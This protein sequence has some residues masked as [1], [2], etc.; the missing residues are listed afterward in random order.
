MFMQPSKILIKINL[1]IDFKIILTL[2]ATRLGCIYNIETKFYD[3]LRITKIV[4]FH[5]FL[6]DSLHAI[7]YQVLGDPAPGRREASVSPRLGLAAHEAAGGGGGGVLGGIIVRKQCQ[8][9]IKMFNF[10]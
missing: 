7:L 5:H 8:L 6:L 2:C 9:Q 10:F 1:F 3:E 4:F